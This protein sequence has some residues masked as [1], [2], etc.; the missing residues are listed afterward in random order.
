MP[1]HSTCFCWEIMKCDKSANCA[2]RKN[3]DRPCWEIARENGDDY[4]HYFN[5]CRDCIVY[6][7][8]TENSDLSSRQVK[9]IVDAKTSCRLSREIENLSPSSKNVNTSPPL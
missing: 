7:L 2:A 1:S 3:P 6:V 9:N 4:R 8:K 5:I